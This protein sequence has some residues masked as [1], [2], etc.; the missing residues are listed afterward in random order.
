MTDQIKSTVNCNINNY[1]HLFVLL[2]LGGI[3]DLVNNKEGWGFPQVI[4]Q[5]A[6]A[7]QLPLIDGCLV[8]NI[9][10]TI[11]APN[12]TIT[13]TGSLLRLRNV[14]EHESRAISKSLQNLLRD[15][16][17]LL[18][19]EALNPTGEATSSANY[20][21]VKIITRDRVFKAHKAILSGIDCNI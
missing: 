8:I 15:F 16:G 17:K 5:N 19:E 21:D 14:D 13:Y 10:F 4:D 2:I 11:F 3:A 18:E 12:P 1:C 20:S 7:D 9:K 6:R